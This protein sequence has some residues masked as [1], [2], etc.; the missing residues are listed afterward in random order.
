MINVPIKLTE[1]NWAK[2]TIPVVTVFSWVFNHKEF[3]RQSIESILM[4]ETTFPVEIIIQDDASNDGTRQVIEE[5]QTKYPNLFNNIFFSENQYSQG[6]SI[7]NNLLEKPRGKYIALNHGDDYW[8]DTL[9]LQKQVDYLEANAT[10]SISYHN[11]RISK[12]G[13][14]DDQRLTYGSQ[15]EKLFF[16]DLLNGNYTHTCSVVFRMSDLK[17]IYDGM[18]DNVLAL[19]LLKDGTYAYYHNETM[20]VYRVH[21][22]GV[23]SKR[24]AK[25]RFF[26]QSNSEK[27]IHKHFYRLNPSGVSIRYKNFFLQS[28]FNLINERF[29]VHSCL[30]LLK[31]FK[32]EKSL[33]NMGINVLRWLRLIFVRKNY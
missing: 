22:G 12:K 6:R 32:Y 15:P 10:C 19:E 5:Y 25:D 8:I 3:I 30:A 26:M 20:A 17:V 14:L 29:Y 23:W 33:S 28:S 21:D 11:N 1:Q 7:M 16:S 24:N 2:D 31:Y 27:I 9:K 18:D 4:Q 13:L